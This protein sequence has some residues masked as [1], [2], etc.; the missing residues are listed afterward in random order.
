M[1]E[2]QSQPWY[3][4]LRSYQLGST[5]PLVRLMVQQSNCFVIVER[6]RAMHQMQQERALE[7]SGELR[8]S[9]RFGK[10]QMVAADYSMSPSI[11]FTQKDA[12]GIGGALS[13]FSGSLGVLGSLAGSLK[14]RK[15]RP[16]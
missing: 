1:I 10:G 3:A 16:C 5:V 13:R 6:G 12:G 2:N 15:P 14:F 11:T 9:S 4:Q 8:Q 7:R